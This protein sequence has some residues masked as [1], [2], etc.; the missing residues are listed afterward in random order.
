MAINFG[1]GFKATRQTKP[2]I[3]VKAIVFSSGDM[4][5]QETAPSCCY[6]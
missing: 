5:T 2:R 4:R 6:R 3:V 1:I